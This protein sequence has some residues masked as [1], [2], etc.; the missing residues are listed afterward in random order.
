ML[1]IV[2]QV[3]QAKCPEVKELNESV[4]FVKIEW[5]LGR[6]TTSL[7]NLA[8]INV[9]T[10]GDFR[11]TA[12]F[13]VSWSHGLIDNSAAGTL[14]TYNME[15]IREIFRRNRGKF[16]AAS[17]QQL[18]LQILRLS[19]MRKIWQSRIE[20]TRKVCKWS[21]MK[22]NMEPLSRHRVMN[23]MNHDVVLLIP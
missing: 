23:K 18:V 11:H 22:K 19:R 4:L 20:K 16:W 21:G 13:F 9:L 14:G 8:H 12:F 7:F 6:R 1:Q 10:A 5:P 17:R 2:S 15:L 3:Y